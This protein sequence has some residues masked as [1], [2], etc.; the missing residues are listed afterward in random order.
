MPAHPA[1]PEHCAMRSR[2]PS[3]VNARARS[4]VCVRVRVCAPYLFEQVGDVARQ[5]RLRV[6]ARRAQAAE[7]AELLLLRRRWC[8]G[9]RASAGGWQLVARV[10]PA[11]SPLSRVSADVATPSTPATAT[12]A[13]TVAVRRCGLGAKSSE[14]SAARVGLSPRPKATKAP[15]AAL[16]PAERRVRLLGL[17]PELQMLQVARGVEGDRLVDGRRVGAAGVSPQVRWMPGKAWERGTCAAG[18]P[19]A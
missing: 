17:A 14:A 10:P 8:G 2:A 9:V 11:R 13:A 18:G 15:P 1:L 5:G 12:A 16:A 6:G 4:F 7:P 19:L 3:A